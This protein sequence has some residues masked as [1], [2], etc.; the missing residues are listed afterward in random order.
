MHEG[1]PHAIDLIVNHEIQLLVNTPEGKHAQRDDYTM[2]QAAIAHR[3][4]YTTTLSAAEAAGD[5]VQ[6]LRGQGHSVRPLQAWHAS[7]AQAPESEAEA[8]V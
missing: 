6:A 1:R 8:L 4:P 5:A 3:V 2:R 7:M